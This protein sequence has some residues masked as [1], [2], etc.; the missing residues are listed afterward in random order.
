MRVQ[1][2]DENFFFIFYVQKG[3]HKSYRTRLNVP[4]RENNK[5]R[6]VQN[7]VQFSVKVRS[8]CLDTLR[9][10]EFKS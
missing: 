2:Q 7:H 1:G 6:E 9:L 10:K 3:E 4:T 5:A 8:R